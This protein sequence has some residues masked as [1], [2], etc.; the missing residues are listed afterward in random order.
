[1]NLTHQVLYYTLIILYFLQIKQY[2]LLII[3]II[4]A[5]INGIFVKEPVVQ[6][7]TSWF[8]RSSSM[9]CKINTP[10]AEVPSPTVKM[11]FLHV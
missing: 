11:S 2:S 6:T 3:Y 5:K 10:N 7:P 1:M 4:F 8:T 9:R